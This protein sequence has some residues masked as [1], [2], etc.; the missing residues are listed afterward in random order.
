MP[1]RNI[2]I[3]FGL[4]S[5]ISKDGAT[6]SIDG[7]PESLWKQFW[8]RSQEL[9]PEKG[10][11]AWSAVLCE[12]IASICDGSTHTF[13]MTDI[14]ADAKR[15]FD[16][17]CKEANSREDQVI[18]QAYKAAMLGKLHLLKI[19]DPEQEDN[20]HTMIV[21]GLPDKAWQGWEKIAGIAGVQDANMMLAMFFES[22][23]NDQL[24]FTKYDN[25]QT[26]TTNGTQ[27][28]MGNA[29]KSATFTPRRSGDSTH[30]AGNFGNPTRVSG[31]R[32]KPS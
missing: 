4:K 3:R 30:R 19:R 31:N 20:T 13:I 1:N 8:E 27:S 29:Q 15:A 21:I 7:I 2:D 26:N 22:A 17:T 16:E 6:W 25:G 32:P 5:S 28:G 24:R 23:A 12:A 10:E 9:M 18:A 11:N 14:P